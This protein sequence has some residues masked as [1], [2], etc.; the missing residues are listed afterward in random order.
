M[1]ESNA[2]LV[3][4]FFA[5]DEQAFDKLVGRHHSLVFR[6]CLRML[7]H[8]QDAEDATQET[9]SRMARYLSRWDQRRPLEP[10]LVTIAGNRCRSLIAGKQ[11]RHVFPLADD[12]A[13]TSAAEQQNADQLAEEVGL[14]LAQ[15]P[16]EQRMAFELFH[17]QSMGYADIAAKMGR[18]VGTIKTWVHRTRNH[19]IES[20]CQREV[21]SANGGVS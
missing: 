11:R 3:E 21:L 4:Q 2:A 13:T 8:R 17:Q 18:P 16:A 9:F 12:P 6:V 15:L 1:D 5:C 19:L 14:A 10:W 7:G 20:L